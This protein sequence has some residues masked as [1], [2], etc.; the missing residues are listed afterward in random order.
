MTSLK[1]ILTNTKEYN[2]EAQ[3]IMF[4]NKQGNQKSSD[5]QKYFYDL[6]GFRRNR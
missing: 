6:P 3:A 1:N 5:S 2:S 4:C